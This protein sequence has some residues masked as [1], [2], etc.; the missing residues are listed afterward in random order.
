MQLSA[1]LPSTSASARLSAI[2]RQTA[3]GQF[4]PIHAIRA[5]RRIPESCGLFVNVVNAVPLTC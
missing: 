5:Y 1:T 4:V 2:S 3:P